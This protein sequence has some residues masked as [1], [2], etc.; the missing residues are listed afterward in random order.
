MLKRP[1]GEVR[2]PLT[3]AERSRQM[4]R[5]RSAGTAP[6]LIVRRLCHR[7]GYRFRLQRRDLPGTPDM[8][9]PGRRCA[10]FIHGCWWHGHACRRGE[11]VPSN[12]RDYWKAKVSRNRARDVRV[13]QELRAAGWR[14]L[15]V[16]E[17][18]TRDSDR[19]VHVLEAFLGPAGAGR[20]RRG[21]S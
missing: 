11:R 13:V 1:K 2:D 21:S 8:V 3:P 16:W 12:N 9:F 4:G 17:C 19:L 15:V 20:Q 14:V 6:E 7:L 10:I 5:V 18:Q